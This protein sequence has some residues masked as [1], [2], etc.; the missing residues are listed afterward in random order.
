MVIFIRFDKYWLRSHA[1]LAE[2]TFIVLI[3][4]KFPKGSEHIFSEVQGAQL[5]RRP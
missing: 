3:F 4:R 2:S 5:L 1:D